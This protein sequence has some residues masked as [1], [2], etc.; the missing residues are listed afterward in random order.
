VQCAR[1]PVDTDDD[2]GKSV[3]TDLVVAH[4]GILWLIPGQVEWLLCG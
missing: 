3:L 1:R 4:S 2:H